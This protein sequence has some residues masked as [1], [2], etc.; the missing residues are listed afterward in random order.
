MKTIAL[1]SGGKSSEHSI[2]LASAKNV[3]ANIDREKY[4]LLLVGVDRQGVMSMYDPSSFCGGE[5][6]SK[7]ELTDPISSPLLVDPAEPR[8]IDQDGKAYDYDVAFPVFHGVYGEGGDMQ[9][10]FEVQGVDYVGPGLLASALCMDKINFKRICRASGVDVVPEVSWDSRTHEMPSWNAVSD[11][12]GPNV[13]V[14]PSRSGSSIGV[15]RASNAQEYDHAVD[16]AMKE[17]VRILV[18]QAIEGRELECA[19]LGGLPPHL[20][21]SGVGEIKGGD[22]YSFDEKYSTDS[23]TET[24]NSAEI[25]PALA[26]R[27][28]ETCVRLAALFT[29]KGLSRMDFFA[30]ADGT[31]YINEINTIPGFT[32]ISL[33]PKLWEASG[34]SQKQLVTEL[35]ESAGREES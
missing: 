8:V 7:L 6:M 15:G 1:F 33:Y 13:Y 9:G 31:V 2:A 21:V 11:K 25:D 24:T 22:Y 5:E 30:A 20:K 4:N 19:V 10:L 28:K 29:V 35:I 27:I 12:L 16:Q 26:N 23:Q 32:A 18:E 14:K 3:A 34:L 17:D